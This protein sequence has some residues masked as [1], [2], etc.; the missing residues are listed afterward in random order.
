MIRPYVATSLRIQ[1]EVQT[2]KRDQGA[3][4]AGRAAEKR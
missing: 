3:C 1:G 4:H 2:W